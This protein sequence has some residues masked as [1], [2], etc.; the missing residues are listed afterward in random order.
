MQE[1][2]KT[3]DGTVEALDHQGQPTCCAA[4]E[5][6]ETEAESLPKPHSQ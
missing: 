3:M 4:K 5:T 1:T 6:E 2:F